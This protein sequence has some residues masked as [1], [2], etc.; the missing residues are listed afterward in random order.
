[1]ATATAAKKTAAKKATVKRP[2]KTTTPANGSSNG[3]LSRVERA[4]YMDEFT[5]QDLVERLVAR[6][7]ELDMTATDVAKIIGASQPTMSQFE[8][9]KIRVPLDMAQRYAR[10]VGCRLAIGLERL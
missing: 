7:N 2:A 8:S 5:R 9:G 1:M 3:A 10:A 4:E 6:R